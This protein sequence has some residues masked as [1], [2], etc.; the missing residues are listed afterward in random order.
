MKHHLKIPGDRVV[1]SDKDARSN[2]RCRSC[3]SICVFESPTCTVLLNTLV[4]TTNTV[5]SSSHTPTTIM[6]ASITWA[7]ATTLLAS[8]VSG[9]DLKAE[10]AGGV[11][12]RI[13]GGHSSCPEDD[14]VIS[15]GT[16]VGE[17]VSLGNGVLSLSCHHP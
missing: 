9:L 14:G 3:I 8:S 5:D 16:A 15:N 11:F 17:T 4:T 10:H 1:Y 2:V 13:H 6:R 7:A 12:N